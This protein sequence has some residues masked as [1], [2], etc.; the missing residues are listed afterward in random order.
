M[1]FISLLSFAYFQFDL[2]V[3][4]I[5]GGLNM[6]LSPTKSQGAETNSDESVII[7]DLNDN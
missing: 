5:Y 7:I 6:P 3:S 2:F 4:A 1:S